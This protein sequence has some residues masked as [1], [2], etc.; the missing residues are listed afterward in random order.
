[1]EVAEAMRATFKFAIYLKTAKALGL[2][3]PYSMQLLAE[4]VIG[5]T[6]FVVMPRACCWHS[7]PLLAKPR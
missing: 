1:L 5:K 2:S 3:V 7:S 6:N 4:K